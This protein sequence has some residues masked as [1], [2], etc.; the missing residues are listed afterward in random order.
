MESHT[1]T[2][3]IRIALVKTLLMFFLH[4]RSN[5]LNSYR[6]YRIRLWKLFD[7]KRTQRLDMVSLKQILLSM[8]A[9][10][11][12]KRSSR[13][14][15]ICDALDEMD[16]YEQREVL[17]PFF[18][19]M[20]KAGFKIFLTS[21]PYPAD[22]HQSFSDAIQLDITPN[23]D[24]LEAHIENQLNASPSFVNIIQTSSSVKLKD[25]VSSRIQRKGNV[26][27]CAS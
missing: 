17:L 6:R 27:A 4:L 3:V 8:P 22:V 26:F 5:Y 7:E 20:A 9:I 21:P 25:V 13:A 11:S 1:F 18:Y 15:I 10:F 24:D 14:F 16:E 23:N 12:D 19:D 2:V